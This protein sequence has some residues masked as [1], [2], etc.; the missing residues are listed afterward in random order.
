MFFK[1]KKPTPATIITVERAV[2][3]RFLEWKKNIIYTDEQNVLCYYTYHLFPFND[4]EP[5]FNAFGQCIY[6]EQI[7]KR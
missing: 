5:I 2:E 7:K 4:R 1:K 3:D 6:N